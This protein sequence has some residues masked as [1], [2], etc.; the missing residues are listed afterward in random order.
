VYF[1]LVVVFSQT[2]RTEEG[3]LE[4]RE[5]ELQSGRECVLLFPF[6]VELIGEQTKKVETRILFFAKTFADSAVSLSALPRKTT[7][8]K[9]LHSKTCTNAVQQQH[10]SITHPLVHNTVSEIR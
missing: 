7:T 10:S 4:E 3:K 9:R 8:E 1:F 2:K 5:R 6:E